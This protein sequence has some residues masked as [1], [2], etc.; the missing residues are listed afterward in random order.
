MSAT[1][2]RTRRPSKRTVEPARSAGHHTCVT[3]PVCGTEECKVLQELGMF[4]DTAC[5]A[6]E[7]TLEETR[8]LQKGA[9]VSQTAEGAHTSRG[10][11]FR[12]GT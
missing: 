6:F 5:A 8:R 9:G 12:S 10:K 3:C 2:K 1:T 7:A 11:D 4:C